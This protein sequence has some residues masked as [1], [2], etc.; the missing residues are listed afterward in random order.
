M[1]GICQG[2]SQATLWKSAVSSSMCKREKASESPGDGAS[3]V[4][5]SL[6]RHPRDDIYVVC[7]WSKPIQPPSHE[8]HVL[9]APPR[10]GSIIERWMDHEDADHIDPQMNSSLNGQLGGGA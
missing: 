4:L 9:K 5:F 7:A 8:A 10:A 1:Y 2:V 3:R 6:P